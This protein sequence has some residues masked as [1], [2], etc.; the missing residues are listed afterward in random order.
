VI[1]VVIK[2]NNR[3]HHPGS[4]KF[5]IVVV[6][7]KVTVHA[8]RKKTKFVIVIIIEDNRARHP[9]NT[10]LVIVVIIEK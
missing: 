6:I 4:T 10:K 2:D 9:K 3:A 8:T 1:A 7:N 5:A